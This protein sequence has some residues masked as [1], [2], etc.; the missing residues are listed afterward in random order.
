MSREATLA[1]LADAFGRCLL[2][3]SDREDERRIRPGGRKYNRLHR[4][5]RIIDRLVR[6][7]SNSTWHRRAERIHRE[8][9]KI[10]P[11]TDRKV[12]PAALWASA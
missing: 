6:R 8:I 4:I 10:L 11:R 5:A 1:G 3:N 2:A 9:S 12:R 7:P